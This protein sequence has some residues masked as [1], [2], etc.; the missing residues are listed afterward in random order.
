M[1]LLCYSCYLKF[2]YECAMPSFVLCSDEVYALSI[3]KP[4][5]TFT[6]A[7]NIAKQL[8]QPNNHI[9]NGMEEANYTQEDVDAYV[10]LLYGVSKDWGAAGLSLGLVYS[11]NTAL[12]AVSCINLF[13]CYIS[14]LSFYNTKHQSTITKKLKKNNPINCRRWAT[15]RI[16]TTLAIT[17]STPFPCSSLTFPGQTP[18][19]PKTPLSS[20][21]PTTS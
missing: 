8:I 10:H 5:N 3:F 16:S 19:S 9:Q 18:T 11:Q 17:P 6:S 1:T 2:L 14:I 21:K 20:K 13:D 15:W 12:N 7:L 4:G